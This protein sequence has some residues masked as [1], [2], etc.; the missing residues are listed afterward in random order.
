MSDW[1]A[2]VFLQRIGPLAFMAKDLL[3]VFVDSLETKITQLQSPAIL[4]QPQVIFSIAHSIKGSAG[5]VSCPK[6]AQSALELEHA[7]QH[8]STAE[9]S[10]TLA[11][12]LAQAQNDLGLIKAYLANL[13]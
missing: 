4:Q 8:I 10:A 5:Q 11:E 9:L 3:Q 12:L 2:E 6:L 1:S 13:E 7:T